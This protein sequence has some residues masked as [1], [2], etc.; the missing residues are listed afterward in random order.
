ATLGTVAPGISLGDT[1]IINLNGEN[2]TIS[3]DPAWELSD[4]VNAINAA[5]TGSP[6]S[7]VADRLELTANTPIEIRFGGSQPIT[8]ANLNA[9]GLD[10][11]TQARDPRTFTIQVGALPVQT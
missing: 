1:F 5:F 4:L 9:L 6:A 8:E 2:S 11:M 3:L 10:F 7:A